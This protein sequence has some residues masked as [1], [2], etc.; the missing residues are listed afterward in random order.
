MDQFIA[1]LPK[2]ELHVHLEGCVEPDTLWELAQRHR[3]PLAAAGESALLKLY[4]TSDFDGFLEAFKT[5]CQHLRTPEDYERVTYLV[6]CRLAQQNVRY[7]EITLSAGVILRKGENLQSQFEGVEAGSRRAREDV[8]IRAQ[9]I[10]D[11]VRQFGPEAA[12]AVAR[13]AVSLRDRGVVGLGIGGDERLAQPELFRE[14]FDY[15]RT[16]GL[17]LTAHAGEIAGP[18]SIWSALNVLRA[19]RLGHALTAARDPRLVDY[20]ADTRIPLEICLTSNVRTGGLADLAQHP[21]RHYLERGLLIS[22][23]TDDPALFGTDLNREYRLAHQLFGL[24]QREL[25]RLAEASFQAS[26]LPSE[27]KAAYLADFPPDL[28][29]Q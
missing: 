6:L 2:A 8:G 13:A 24:G 25:T 5:V 19:E 7:A 22:L 3:T 9:W 1:Q 23:N 21:A 11:A 15:A 26:F 4:A 20:L 10:F 28:G 17:R 16:Q 18:E 12:M 29:T 14:V 27:G